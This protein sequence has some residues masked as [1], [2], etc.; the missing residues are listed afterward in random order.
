MV[1]VKVELMFLEQRWQPGE[2]TLERDGH[3]Y[4]A[5]YTVTVEML[6]VKTHTETRAL[7]IRD[8]EPA[9]L[10][11]EALADIVCAQFSGQR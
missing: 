2:V 5:R 6:H 11:H 4:G 10:A 7:E 8:R 9:M 3:Q 1:V